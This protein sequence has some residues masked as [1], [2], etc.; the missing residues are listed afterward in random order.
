MSD[1]SAETSAPIRNKAGTFRVRVE[2]DQDGTGNPRDNDCNTGT[3]VL[4]HRGYNLPSE[5]DVSFIDQIDRAME[6]G[7]PLLA[8][9]YLRYL[10]LTTAANA[11]VLT[12]YGYDHGQ[13]RLKAGER[14]GSFADKW[15]SGIAGVIYALR[16]DI[17]KAHEGYPMPSDDDIATWLKSEVQEYDTWANGEMT[18]FIVEVQCGKCQ[19]WRHVDSCWGFYSVSDAMEQGTD[20]IPA[21]L[22][23]VERC[24]CEWKLPHPLSD[25][26]RAVIAAMFG[27]VNRS[28]VSAPDAVWTEIQQ[29]FPFELFENRPDAVTYDPEAGW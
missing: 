7:G 21:D 2:Y 9:R 23:G 14:T 19:A 27:D 6:R 4:S 12:V 15:D 24:E 26:A 16:D 17:A 18:G 10:T 8:A 22:N 25:A 11:V 5:G 20:Q 28:G 13:L 29:A 3:M 1:Y